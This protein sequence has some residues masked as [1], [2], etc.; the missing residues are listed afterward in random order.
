MIGGISMATRWTNLCGLTLTLLLAANAHA[1]VPSTMPASPICHVAAHAPASTTQPADEWTR[2]RES[3][4]QLA[5]AY[6]VAGNYRL[7][8]NILCPA[9][10]AARARDARQF[11]LFSAAMGRALCFTVSHHDTEGSPQPYLSE[12]LAIARQLEDT[13]TEAAVLN[14]LG[15]L[16]ASQSKYDEAVQA[17]DSAAQLAEALNDLPTAARI[18]C[19]LAIALARAGRD[20]VGAM[21][22]ARDAIARLTDSTSKAGLLVGLARCMATGGD[23][24]AEATYRSAIELSQRIGDDR[25]AAFACGYLGNHFEKLGRIDDAVSAT[26]RARFIAQKLRRDDALYRWEWQLG[27]LYQARGNL[28]DAIKAYGRAVTSLSRGNTRDDVALA[29]AAPI[30]TGSFRVEVGGLYYGLADLHLQKCDGEADTA[31][32]QAH[33]RAARNA[34]ERFKSAE[35]KNYFEDDCLKLA[36]ADQKDIDRALSQDRQTAIVYIIPLADRTELLLSLPGDASEPLLW[37]APPLKTTAAELLKLTSDYREQI[38]AQGDFHYKS[39]DGAAVKLY[40]LL[41]RPIDGRLR[42]NQIDTLVFVPDGDL[43]SVAPAGLYDIERKRFLVEDYA[44]AITPGLMLSAPQPIGGERNVRVLAGGLSQQRTVTVA[45]ETRTFRELKMVPDE[46][47]G[48]RQVY[49]DKRSTTLENESFVKDNVGKQL[50]SSTYAIVHLATH[51]K[52]DKDVRRTYVLT[53][54]EQPMDMSQLEQ[55]IEPSQFRGQPVELLSLSACETAT[56][57]EGRAALGLAGVAV[58]AGARSALATLWTAEDAAAA[59]LIPSFYSELNQT[60]VSKAAAL[61]RAQV[62]M[63]SNVDDPYDRHPAVWA[64]YVIIGNWR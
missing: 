27:R 9:R 29:Y 18:R 61:Q 3:Q 28:D 53:R 5:A 34:I 46:L 51:A 50:E 10:E 26:R 52:F 21:D 39:R 1:D 37:R 60:S 4:R 44:L 11:M 32:V 55:I 6:Q 64:Q 56:G 8:L 23:D 2:Q 17:F 43:R 38:T 57:D 31:L 20:A 41:V 40:D 22:S 45:G 7:A 59:R 12:A 63:L 42:E 54:D 35:L 49:G 30:T 13:A 47:A 62:R 14:D 19:N 16:Y 15:N 25:I 36:E 48:V 24:R 33:L 58:R